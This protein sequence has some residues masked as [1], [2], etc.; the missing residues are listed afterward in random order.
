MYYPTETTVLLSV[1]GYVGVI[2]SLVVL[3]YSFNRNAK[4]QRKQAEQRKMLAQLAALD[5][6]DINELEDLIESL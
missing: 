3:G 2:A 4:Y 6:A 5:A 1:I